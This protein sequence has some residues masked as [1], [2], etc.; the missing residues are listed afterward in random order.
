MERIEAPP[1]LIDKAREKPN[2]ARARKTSF[3]KHARQHHVNYYVRHRQDPMDPEPSRSP[4]RRRLLL[5]PGRAIARLKPKRGKNT[6]RA[7]ATTRPRDDDSMGRHTDRFGESSGDHRQISSSVSP[8]LR[9]VVF[10]RTRV[11]HAER[12]RPC[13]SDAH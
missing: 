8:S 10:R 7:T 3:H 11:V 9:R 2:P 12:I 5:D 1:C 4:T 13:S 6:G